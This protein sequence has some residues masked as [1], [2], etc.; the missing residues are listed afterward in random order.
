[1]VSKEIRFEGSDWISLSLVALV[2]MVMN[3]L[4]SLTGRKFPD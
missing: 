1:M 2:N 4:V 3:L